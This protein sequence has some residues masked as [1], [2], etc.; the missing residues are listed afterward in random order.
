MASE[1]ERMR[2]H[3]SFS[4]VEA[5]ISWC[6]QVFQDQLLRRRDREDDLRVHK[7]AHI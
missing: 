7:E 5:L 1:S 3:S 2:T 4:V 6:C